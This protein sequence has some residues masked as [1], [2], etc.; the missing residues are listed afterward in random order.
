MFIYNLSLICFFW[1]FLSF[2][3][4]NFKTLYDWS[5]FN[6]NSFHLFTITVLLLSMAGVPPFLG[7]FSKIFIIAL[8][9][10]KSIFLLIIFLVV[11]LLLSLYFYVQNI[12]FLYSTNLQQNNSVYFLNERVNLFYYY[13]TIFILYLIIF[14]LVYIEEILLLFLW[15]FF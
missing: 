14:G 12:R 4:L 10:N 15:L 5:H 11:V 3:T 2:S 1:S 9:L 13:I 6:L 8:I 7:F